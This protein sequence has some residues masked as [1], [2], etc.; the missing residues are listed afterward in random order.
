MA[1][2]EIYVYADW[3]GIS[4]P[5]LIGTL[6]VDRTRGKDFYGFSYADTWL[7]S[8][9]QAILSRSGK[10]QNPRKGT[11]PVCISFQG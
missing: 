3:E 11:I 2:K 10:A 7:K 8:A 1:K 4:G 5:E 6:T 9:H